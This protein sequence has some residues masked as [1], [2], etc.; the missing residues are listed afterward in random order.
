MG[1]EEKLFVLALRA[2]FFRTAGLILTLSGAGM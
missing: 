2:A 1:A